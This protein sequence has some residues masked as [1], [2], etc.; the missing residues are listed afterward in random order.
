MSHVY[1]R[2][3]FFSFDLS[4]VHPFDAIVTTRGREGE[5]KL[6]RGLEERMDRSRLV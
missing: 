4:F 6:L 5:S 2:Y 3:V 1:P